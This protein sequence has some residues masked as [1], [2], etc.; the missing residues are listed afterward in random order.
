MLTTLI[1]GLKSLWPQRYQLGWEGPRS[2]SSLSLSCQHLL[3]LLVAFFL[4]NLPR[5]LTAN[6]ISWQSYICLQP[7]V[8]Y[9]SRLYSADFPWR[10]SH[11]FLSSWSQGCAVGCCQSRAWDPQ[12]RG[13]LCSVINK[14]QLLG[15]YLF[16]S[17]LSAFWTWG[18]QRLCQ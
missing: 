15:S 17:G 3:A 4:V 14:M 9:L 7:W 5:D 11:S 6:S 8:P 18:S 16:C 2:S 13:M 1:R 12:G 10:L